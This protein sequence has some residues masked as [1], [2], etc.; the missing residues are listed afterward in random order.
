MN[1]KVNYLIPP[2][3]FSLKVVI[4]IKKHGRGKKRLTYR[5]AGVNAWKKLKVCERKKEGRRGTGVYF[6]MRAPKKY[7]SI[8]EYGSCSFLIIS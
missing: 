5:L 7:S 4:W 2:P 6:I 8:S 1:E 3:N